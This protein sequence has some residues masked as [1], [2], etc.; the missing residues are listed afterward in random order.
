MSEHLYHVTVTDRYGE[1]DAY[2][3][4]GT[5]PDAGGVQAVCEAVARWHRSQLTGMRVAYLGE[6]VPLAEIVTSVDE[7]AE[8]GSC[9]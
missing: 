7:L 6:I 4:S 2:I 9:D 3:S 8:I 5:T 1:T